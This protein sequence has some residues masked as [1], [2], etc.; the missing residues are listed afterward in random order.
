MKFL[1]AIVIIE[2]NFSLAMM[3]K[4][5]HYLGRR[6]TTRDKLMRDVNL[7]EFHDAKIN[8]K[9]CWANTKALFISHI[10][11]SYFVSIK[12]QVLLSI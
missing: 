7:E 10:Q 1:K 11:N 2:Y 6:G 12:I 8:F 3:V 4:A 5:S 9:S